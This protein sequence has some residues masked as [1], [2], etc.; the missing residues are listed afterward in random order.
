MA[1]MF[2]SRPSWKPPNLSFKTNKTKQTLWGKITQLKINK[3][4]KQKHR[5]KYWIKNVLTLCLWQKLTACSVCH[6]ILFS[7]ASGTLQTTRDKGTFM[8]VTGTNKTNLLVVFS[9]SIIPAISK[10]K[11]CFTQ[12]SCHPGNRW[13]VSNSKRAF[14]F[15]SS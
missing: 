5:S 1:R 12:P 11:W 14:V 7:W 6:T 9:S 3:L 2:W 15:R 13:P 8:A 4:I 10:K